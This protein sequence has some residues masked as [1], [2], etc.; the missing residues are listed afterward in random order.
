MNTVFDLN[1]SDRLCDS[2]QVRFV[3]GNPNGHSWAQYRRMVNI[4]A[5]SRYLTKRQ[6]FLVWVCAN[7]YRNGSRKLTTT[8]IFEVA[9][10][11]LQTHQKAAIAV[12]GYFGAE[13]VSGE[14]ILELVEQ[15]SGR[16]VSRRTLYR[17]CN[18]QT[19]NTTTPRFSTLATYSAEQVRRIVKTIAA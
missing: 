2:F 8:K 17:K 6:A 16:R 13:R 3:C 4:P 5:R 1:N 9:N 19:A 10:A 11:L 14:Q 15:H 18:G 7:L 12:M